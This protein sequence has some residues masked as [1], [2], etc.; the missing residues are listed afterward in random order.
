MVDHTVSRVIDLLGLPQPQ[1][2]RWTG[3]NAA[4]SINIP[5]N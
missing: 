3:L 5:G 4:C 1:A 2:E